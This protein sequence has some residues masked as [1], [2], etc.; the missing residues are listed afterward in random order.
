[1]NIIQTIKNI[2]IS[3]DIKLS[4]VFNLMALIRTIVCLIFLVT[5]CKAY[6]VFT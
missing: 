4:Y 6:G 3:I 1:M 5:A 2:L